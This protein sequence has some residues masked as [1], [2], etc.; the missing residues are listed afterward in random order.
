MMTMYVT[1]TADHT[2]SFDRDYYVGHHIPLVMELWQ[3]MGLKSATA[4]FPSLGTSTGAQGSV[5]IC[6]C[7][8]ENEAALHA[9]L[10][11]PEA[12]TIMA[13]VDKFTKIKPALSC[14][15]AI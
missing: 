6:E 14:G 1:Y 5:A 3:P 2:A 12:G 15:H 7:I 13:D 8:F 11:S 4:F 10:S 9:A